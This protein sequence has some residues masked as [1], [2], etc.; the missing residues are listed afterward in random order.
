MLHIA[1]RI[2]TRTPSSHHITK[3]LILLHWLPVKQRITYKILLMTCK[4]INNIGP[5]YLKMLLN[6]SVPSRSL[7][8][9]SKNLMV[10]PKTNTKT[11]GNCAFSHSA[12]VL[13][14]PLLEPLKDVSN[15]SAF[16]AKLKTFFFKQ[17]YNLELLLF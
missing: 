7:R 17:A 11:F 9:S 13:W 6:P 3:V 4:A 10:V 8:S 16:N 2:V 15:V 5:N 12:A 1:A 14:N